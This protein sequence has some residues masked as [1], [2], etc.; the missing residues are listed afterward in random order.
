M[1]SIH[2]DSAWSP[3]DAVAL[4][5]APDAEAQMYALRQRT[6]TRM[7][8]LLG[9]SPSPI[10]A[11]ARMVNEVVAEARG[12]GIP[13]AV[14]AATVVNRT[15]GDVNVRQIREVYKGVDYSTI[16]EDLG[17][18]LPGEI[19]N[20]RVSAGTTY[21]ELRQRMQ[22][23]ERQL[24]TE[25]GFDTRIYDLGGVGNPLLRERLAQRFRDECGVPITA[26]QTY[27]SIG[28]LDGI[29]KSVRG[30]NQYFREKH[31]ERVGFA[32][33]APGFAVPLWQARNLGME[34]IN[35]PTREAD[36]FEL[37][38]ADMAALLAAHPNLR[39]LYLTVSN[40]PTAF[41][42]RPEELQAVLDAIVLDGR[43]MAIVADLAYIGTGPVDE[44]RARMAVF[45]T[46]EGLER[47]VFV[48]SFSKVFTLTGDRMGYVSIGNA[49]WA[50]LL[51][52]VWNNATAG[53][54]AEWQLR[55]L[56]YASLFEERPWIQTKIRD[57]YSLRRSALQ[58]ELREINAT[59]HVFDH[60]GLDDHATVYNWSKL[61][62]GVDSFALFEKTGIAGVDG[63]AFGYS[64]QYLRLSVGFIPVRPDQLQEHN[65]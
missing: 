42:Y 35:F 64:P 59:H 34:V 28:A 39:I 2:S 49:K 3:A 9:D 47:T 12:L 50:Q 24:L 54:P 52:G 58:A 17:I 41:A 63:R 6:V 45:L 27:V 23:F 62:P 30:L 65:A 55:F 25:Y 61:A 43:E 4:S 20:G 11:M 40:N 57:L 29:D 13:E 16:G 32:F 14:V 46:P 53:M 33:P 5:P 37:T 18:I 31:G 15:I 1:T 7:R 26:E 19:I 51:A 21:L 36:R 10:R 22:D 8:P 48:N 56:A 44:D 60:I 38:G